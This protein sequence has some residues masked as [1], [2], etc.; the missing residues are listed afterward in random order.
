MRTWL[1][2]I[3]RILLFTLSQCLAVSVIVMIVLSFTK[4]FESGSFKW[5][6]P[7][8]VLII[9]TLL[10]TLVGAMACSSF[11]KS[12]SRHQAFLTFG[13]IGFVAEYGK[14]FMLSLFYTLNLK[15]NIS[16]AAELMLEP[17]L[18]VIGLLSLLAW[19]I[20]AFFF[21]YR[22]RLGIA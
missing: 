1:M 4:L 11:S 7:D 16:L 22:K 12:L 2:A 18:F 6:V 9:I 3:L 10:P 19:I 21:F 13:I 20:L 5:I 17:H 14:L 15:R 8:L